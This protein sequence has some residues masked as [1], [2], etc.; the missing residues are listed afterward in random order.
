VT[1]YTI[2]D[3]AYADLHRVADLILSSFY[4]PSVASPW[5]QLY[6]MGEL[7]RIQQGFAYPAQRD[8]HRMLV[9]IVGAAA[10]QKEPVTTGGPGSGQ[11]VGFCDVDGRPPN[12]PTGFAYNPRPYLSDLCT[13]PAHRR[14][15][16]A[17]ALVEQCEAYC[18]D[19][20]NEP[21]VYIRVERHND[22]AIRLYEGMGY[23]TV[24]DESETDPTA[25][26]AVTGRVFADP[27]SSTTD[28]IRLLRKDLRLN[29]T[30]AVLSQAQ[31][32]SIAVD[33]GL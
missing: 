23:R 19:V 30:T 15:G 27:S 6:R 16:V 21:F 14:Q 12:R 1:S 10:A 32:F 4:D 22:A 3:C 13:D 18:R 33:Q 28:K 25:S 2:R 26:I 17:K 20:L 9:A 29:S 8:S 31:Q 7:N 11:I 24:E 5:R